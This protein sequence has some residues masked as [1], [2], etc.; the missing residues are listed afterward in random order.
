M[1]KDRQTIVKPVDKHA[2]FLR[3]VTPRVNKA[4]KAIELLGN[5]AGAAYAP[6]KAEVVEMFAAIRKKV[7]E[8]EACYKGGAAQVSG[9]AFAEK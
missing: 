9:F 3:V 2:D 8:A 5:Q 1:G 7:D 4:L 6:T